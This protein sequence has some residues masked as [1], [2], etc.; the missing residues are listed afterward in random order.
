M[1]G[2]SNRGQLKAV[3]GKG[4]SKEK[5]KQ[6]NRQGEKETKDLKS[7]GGTKDAAGREIYIYDNDTGS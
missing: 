2:K 6:G 3:P 1:E 5:K 7:G 4:I